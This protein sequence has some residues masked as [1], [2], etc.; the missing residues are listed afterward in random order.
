MGSDRYRSVWI[1]VLIFF[2]IR[3]DAQWVWQSN[4]GL[5]GWNCLV[6]K[7]GSIFTAGVDTL[8]RSTDNGENWTSLPAW[9]D[10]KT[11]DDV[12]VSALAV[13]PS[14][15]G[16][17]STNL[18][19]GTR[20][21]GI[22]RSTNNGESW[23][24]MYG[25]PT[26]SH[27]IY[28]F[29]VSGSTVLA[30]MVGSVVGT[31]DGTVKVGGVLRSTNDGES[32]NYTNA[33]LAYDD[34]T[35]GTYT[36]HC[37]A[38]IK[39]GSSGT[40]YLG[41][42]DG[43]YMSTSDGVGWTRISN[44]LP[45]NTLV[46]SLTATTNGEGGTRITLFAGVWGKGVYRSTDN[47][48]TWS[49]ANDGFSWEGSSFGPMLYIDQFATSAVPSATS[50]SIIAVAFP[51]VYMST[52]GG[53]KWWDTGWTSNGG[54]GALCVNGENVLAMGSGPGNNTPG[55]WEYSL[56]ADTGWVVQPSGTT[57]TLLAVKAV[58]GNTVWTGG[59]QGGVFMTANGGATWT[60]VGGGT[61]GS[62]TVNAVEA[63][64]ANTAFVSTY[65]GNIGNIFRTTNGGSSWSAVAAENG[66]AIG[67]MQMKSASEGYAVGTPVAGKWIVLKTTDGGGAWNSLATGPPEDSLTAS[68]MQYY[69]PFPLRPRGVQLLGDTM[70]FG[71]LSGV[72]Y[73][74]NDLGATWSTGASTVYVNALHFNSSAVGLAGSYSNGSTRSTGNGGTSWDTAS[75]AG[76][77]PITC[78][79]GSGSEFWATTGDAIAYTKN[80]GQAWSFA[81]PGYWGIYAR[82]NALS[83][84]STASSL[85]GWAVGDS[86]MILHYQRGGATSVSD[87][88]QRVPTG[89]ALHQNYP[90]PFNPSTTIRYGIPH[91]S[92]V[93]LT[94]YNTLGQEVAQLVSSDIDA[95]Y[96]EIRFNANNLASG[97][98]FYRIQAGS[99]VETRKLLLI[100]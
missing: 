84:S 95:G 78:I 88:S 86:G 64:D 99:Y 10:A 29:G 57:D 18:F 61:V 36:V 7:E 56:A 27:Y 60:S 69:G 89:Y 4:V 54:A 98:Y 53:G 100:R 50:G 62:G 20:S 5:R 75:A 87:F 43:V 45:L 59:S 66:V 24:K 96:H 37:F 68:A 85:N 19:A 90:N 16:D 46:N 21:G 30:G 48:S 38:S 3:S 41:K 51:S 70:W 77:K 93:T 28:A 35:F 52:D 34:T 23:T 92:H 76:T 13:V 40:F 83:F 82:L 9:S 73:R 14:S 79:D 91:R 26:P 25:S 8:Y 81:D 6:A 39:I 44:G 31:G 32:W 15:T 80:N 2:A 55:V 12:I 11:A 74:T 49:A 94:V 17:G 42:S 47:G 33:G 67:G 97:V 22:Y 1:L 65:S 72:I 71:G 58:N 63:L